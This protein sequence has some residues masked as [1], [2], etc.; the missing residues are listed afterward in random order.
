MVNL[1]TCSDSVRMYIGHKWLINNNLNYPEHNSTNRF[2]NK[3]CS[4][5]LI[6]RILLGV[7]PIAIVAIDTRDPASGLT[8][9][10]GPVRLD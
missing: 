10:V 3:D 6:C 2:L 1:M 8:A 4:N 9:E 5:L 7:C